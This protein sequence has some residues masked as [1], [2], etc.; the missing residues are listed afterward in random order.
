MTPD[1]HR[2][3]KQFI[4][5]FRSALYDCDVAILKDQLNE[6]FAP[7]CNIHLAYPFEDLDGPDALFEQVYQPLLTAVPDLERRDF[8]V[9]AG[10]ANGE[11]WVG[12]GGFY[13]GV[14]ER[15]W[16]DIPPTQH[17][18]AM[19]FH[20]F[21]RIEDDRVV[22]MQALWDIPQVMMQASAWPMMPSLGV[23]WVIPGPA[24]QDGIITSPYDKARA[25]ASVQLVLDM[26]IGLQCSP[27]GIEAM[28]MERYWHPK[29]LWYGPAGI[30]S[31]RRLT[32]F[33]SWHQ[34]PYLKAMPDRK[35]L[36][37]NGVLF[38]DGDYV[39]FTAWPG[40]QVTIT[41]DGW[42]GIPPANQKLT[43]RSLDFWRC[44]N[45]L[46]RENWVMVDMLDVYHQLGVDVS[47]GC[48]K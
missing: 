24:T 27:Q 12:C 26:V 16:L 28:E 10:E 39:G 17:V 32:G 19:R 1:I 13:T 42:L 6:V 45:G 15:P 14:F 20:E 8:I 44:E 31:A 36:M 38:G 22:E 25:D 5:K 33:Q 37:E 30:G 4:N 11:N 41:G 2:Q 3:N 21:F 7:D 23:E 40:L 48:G 43:M 29:M 18:V 34:I 35:P 9:M 47:R 46:L